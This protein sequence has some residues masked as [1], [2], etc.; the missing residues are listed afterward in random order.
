M[1]IASLKKSTVGIFFEFFYIFFFS[2]LLAAKATTVA[3]SPG[4]ER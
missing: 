4:K 3:D 2:R 1:Y